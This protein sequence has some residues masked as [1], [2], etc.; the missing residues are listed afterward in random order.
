M[1]AV[2][3]PRALRESPVREAAQARQCRRGSAGEAVVLSAWWCYCSQ[4]GGGAAVSMA[5]VLL[6]AWRRCC[7][8]V[9]GEWPL[10][11]RLPTFPSAPTQSAFRSDQLRLD[12]CLHTERLSIT[13]QRLHTR[14]ASQHLRAVAPQ[15]SATFGQ[16]NLQKVVRNQ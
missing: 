1:G 5:A 14:T 12:S 3:W 2:G 4:H 8:C 6:S 11:R 13:P 7:C 15:G 16:Y 10:P 9:E